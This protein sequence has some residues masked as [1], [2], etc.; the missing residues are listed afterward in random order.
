MAKV[1][2]YVFVVMLDNCSSSSSNSNGV[3]AKLVEFVFVGCNAC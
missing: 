1:A 2:E 3:L